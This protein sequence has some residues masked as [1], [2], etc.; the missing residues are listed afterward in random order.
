[1]T[2]HFQPAPNLEQLV[3]TLPGTVKALRA[4][5]ERIE[6]EAVRFAPKRGSLPKGRRRHY[7]DM[8]DTQAGIEAGQARATVNNRHFTALFVEFGT[9]NNPAYAPLRRALDAATGKAL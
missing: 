6:K 5:G 3:G 2:T 8:F 7:A 1:M 4:A 9:L